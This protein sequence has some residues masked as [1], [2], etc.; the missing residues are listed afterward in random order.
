MFIAVVTAGRAKYF[1]EFHWVLALSTRGT[2]IQPAHF[3][4]YLDWNDSA[5]LTPTWL[6]RWI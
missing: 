1:L 4:S 5:V 2:S 3:R 6:R